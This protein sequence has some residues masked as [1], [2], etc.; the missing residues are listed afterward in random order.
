MGT[1]HVVA[2]LV[3]TFTLTKD[4]HAWTSDEILA[5]VRKLT[6]THP[7]PSPDTRF[8]FHKVRKDTVPF[9]LLRS[10]LQATSSL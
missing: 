2:F 8:N 5:H 6:T 3:L 10:Y 1:I 4:V 9:A 7:F